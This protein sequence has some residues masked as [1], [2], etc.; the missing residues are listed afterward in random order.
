M[1]R[2]QA[3]NGGGV[4]QKVFE[5]FVTKVEFSRGLGCWIWTGAVCRQGGR[6]RAWAGHRRYGHMRAPI[7]P[8]GFAKA[9]R[10]SLWLFDDEYDPRPEAE[11]DHTCEIRLCV[12]PHHLDQCP[13]EE[14]N[15][16]RFEREDDGR[17]FIF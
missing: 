2:I 13:G 5:R 6:S 8:S 15:A 3:I 14:N 10:V 16:R 1:L 12:A 11:G 4:R 17:E 9:H 7:T